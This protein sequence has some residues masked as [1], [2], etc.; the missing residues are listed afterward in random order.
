MSAGRGGEDGKKGDGDRYILGKRGNQMV[1][2]GICGDAGMESVYE[3]CSCGA[4]KEAEL[5]RKVC[6]VL[7]ERSGAEECWVL[8]DAVKRRGEECR[9]LREGS[10]D[11]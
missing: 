3:K 10:G 11:G 7:G 2:K 8:G 6:Q 5:E 1:R 4:V 9:V